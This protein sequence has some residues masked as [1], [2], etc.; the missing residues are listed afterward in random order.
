MPE[1]HIV[2]VNVGW[3][4]AEVGCAL[5][6][7]MCALARAQGT[8]NHGSATIMKGDQ[9]LLMRHVPTAIVRVVLALALLLGL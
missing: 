1:E 6:D 7:V 8:E 2:G 3:V 9:H 4:P 5:Y